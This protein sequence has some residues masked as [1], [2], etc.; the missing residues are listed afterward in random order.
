MSKLVTA[1]TDHFSQILIGIIEFCLKHMF[2]DVN[3]GMALVVLLAGKGVGV[4][5]PEAFK[6]IKQ[7]SDNVMLPL[8]AIIISFVLTYELISMVIDKNNMHEVD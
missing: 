5:M 6:I 4:V 7:L 8:S 3:D 1:I 2:Q